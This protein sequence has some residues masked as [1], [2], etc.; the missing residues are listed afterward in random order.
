MIT[1]NSAIGVLDSGVGGLTTVKELQKLL[2]KENIIYFGDNKNV[3]YG[4]KSGEEI[5]KL[6]RRMVE[7]LI[8]NNVKVI[9]VACNTISTIIDEISKDYD[10]KIIK[11]I[12]PVVNNIKNTL[13][14]DKVGLIA[15]NFTVKSGYYDKMLGDIKVFK[16]GSGELA[17]IVDSGSIIRDEVKEIIR[18]HI[19]D[20]VQ[21]GNVDTIILGCTHYPI[22]KDLFQ[23]CYPNI[24]FINPAFQ[25][26]EAI[27]KYL[28]EKELLKDEEGEEFKVYTTGEEDKYNIIMNMLNLKMPE[29]I[30]KYND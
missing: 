4:N 10:V 19:N 5:I 27:Y 9:A 21:A 25:Q 7:F 30:I 8:S 26:A 22:I 11:V 3:P 16:K 17:G 20:I 6:T 12:D 15:T 18:C 29:K 13:K 23:E 1:K 14:K 24:N 28:N 2:P